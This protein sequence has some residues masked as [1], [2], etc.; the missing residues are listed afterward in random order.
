LAIEEG[1]T[2]SQ[3]IWAWA[4]GERA[5]GE[6]PGAM[7]SL[8]ESPAT[9]T[10]RRRRA[11]RNYDKTRRGEATGFIARASW[12]AGQSSIGMMQPALGAAS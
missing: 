3:D 9:G 8:V 7:A 1:I 4:E 2:P 6:T 11:D 5:N 10:P 12:P